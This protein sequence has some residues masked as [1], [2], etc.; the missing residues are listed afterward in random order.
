[1]IGKRVVVFVA[2]A[3]FLALLA[4][5]IVPFA[6]LDKRVIVPPDRYLDATLAAFL[7]ADGVEKLR[8]DPRHFYDTA[9]L[10][11][12]RTQLRSTEPF[13]GFA[14]LAAPF[15]AALRPAD[16]DLLERLRWVMVFASLV[17]AYLLFR[18]ADLDVLTS[19]AGAT[20]CLCQPSLLI[21]ISRLQILSIPLLLPALYHALMLWRGRRPQAGHTVALFGWAALYPLCGMINATI[22]I[23]AGLLLLPL[24]AS[25]T[26]QLWRERRLRPLA[27]P[28]GAAVV[29]DALVLAPWLFDRADMRVYTGEAFLG[30]KRWTPTLVPLRLSQLPSFIADP[31]GFGVVAALALMCAAIAAERPTASGRGSAAAE[32]GFTTGVRAHIWIVPLLAVAMAAAGS[33]GVMRQQAPWLGAAYDTGCVLALLLFWRAQRRLPSG[34]QGDSIAHPLALISGGLGVFLCLLSF[35]PVYASNQHQLASRLANIV[36]EAVPPMK[37]VREFD[38]L[39]IFGILF[40]TIYAIVRC[41][42]ALRRRHPILRGAAAG[43]LAAAACTTL[44]SRPLTASPPIEAPMDLVELAA[45]SPNRGAVYVHPYMKWNSR[46]GVLMIAIARELKRPIVNGY[47]GIIPPWFSYATEVLHRYPDPEAL[48]LLRKWKVETVLKMGAEAQLEQLSSPIQPGDVA[49]EEL[50]PSTDVSHPSETPAESSADVRDDASWT[51]L[52]REGVS[53]FAIKLPTGFAA[54]RIEIHFQPNPVAPVPPR[55]DVYASGEAERV[56]LN[57]GMSGQWLESLAADA[58]VRRDNPV[59]TITLVRPASASIEL[60]CRGSPDPPIA[61]IVLIGTR[62]SRP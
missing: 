2:V 62:G 39:W 61:R 31:A 42:H 10:Y 21:G 8:S 7:V 55:V 45:R 26:L 29:I 37:A 24:C 58:L 52:E 56:R 5:L 6:D 43:I 33:S 59:A 54:G 48:W 41:G 4:R 49:I 19:A 32:S 25:A 57:A 50:A 36:L 17:Y 46:S 47:L 60:E 28:I 27:I 14:L 1:M 16:A 23:V 38:R 20:V 15:K 22:A 40:L 44:F 3:V 35:G 53:A 34:S 30:V 11:P 13:L 12:D 9:I 18:A 51:R